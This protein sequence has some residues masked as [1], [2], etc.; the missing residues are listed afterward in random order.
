MAKIWEEYLLQNK[1]LDSSSQYQMRESIRVI[2]QEFEEKARAKFRHLAEKVRK[3]IY[4]EIFAQIKEDQKK[5]ILDEEIKSLNHELGQ[6]EIQ[7]QKEMVALDALIFKSEKKMKEELEQMKQNFEKQMTLYSR[8]MQ[9]KVQ[10]EQNLLIL[11]N[12]LQYLQQKAS[13]L[14]RDIVSLNKLNTP[15]NVQILEEEIRQ[16][17]S[18]RN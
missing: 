9:Y 5:I 3:E 4:N 1:G 8:E 7:M 11:E 15:Q 16:L 2:N 14:D 18:K 17:N 13:D 6:T 10:G 12:G